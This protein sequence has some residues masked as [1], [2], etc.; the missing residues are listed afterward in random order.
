[1][2]DKG[3]NILV[4]FDYDNI[5]LIDPNKIVDSEGKVGDRLVKHENLV[6]Y[7]NLE[8]NVLPRTKLALGS[9]LNDS[10][11]T[12]S[13]GKINFLNPGNKT[14]MDNRYTDEITGKGS[15]QG[16]GVNQ[17]K[18]NAVQNPNKSDDFYLTQSTYSNGTPGAVD[19]GLLGI[20]DIQ[21]A[22]DTSFLPTVTVNLVDVK[23]RALFEGGNNSPYSAFFQLPYPMFYLTLKGYYGKAVRLPLMLQSFTSNFDN[24]TGNF[25]I[26]LKFFGYKYTVM[27]YVNWGAM[28][29]V[30]HMYNNF[31]ST[32]QASTN[33][34][35]GSNLDKMS[36]KQVSRGYQKMKELYSEY[37]SKGLI[38]DDFPEIT[39]TQ[40]KARLDRFIK[41]ILEKFTKENLGSITELDNF[42][43]Q[44]TE[45][46]KKV[47]FYGDSWFE[48][49]M[50]K[51]TSYSLKDS[52][53]VV[54]TYKKDYSDPNKQAEAETKLAGIFTEYQKLLE[55]NS[56]AGK[57]W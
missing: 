24:T 18:L 43:T 13:V 12:V 21:V 48:T 55:S 56:V 47:F 39:I 5:T 40:L 15:L 35:A 22:I 2:V 20:T 3:E 7:A 19:N 50:D 14:F 10:V 49:Y 36:A 27:S 34:P 4:E 11:R 9:A 1:M 25:K 29:A 16:Q 33:T 30:P 53:E 44:L 38:D 51:T 54:Y 37:K 42:Q 31:V 6:F 57:K 46:Q 45:F 28:M 8:C 17:P 32:V 23:G 52:K 41:D 26:T